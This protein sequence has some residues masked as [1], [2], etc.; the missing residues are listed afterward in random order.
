MQRLYELDQRL[1]EESNNLQILQQ[2]KQDIE[3]TLDE[4]KH[5]LASN[6]IPPENYIAS[7]KIQQSL[8][9]EL[10]KVHSDLAEHARVSVLSK[11]KNELLSL[12]K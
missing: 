6:Q 10:C 1:Q 7:K 11:F 2:D 8:Q 4:L 5:R 3:A 12:N 9:L